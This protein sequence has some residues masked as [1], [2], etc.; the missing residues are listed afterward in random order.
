[1][2]GRGLRPRRLLPARALNLRQR[3]EQRRQPSGAGGHVVG[4]REVVRAE[5]A[6]GDG[7]DAQAVGPGAG[8]VARRVPDDDGA[9]ARPVPGAARG[10]SAAAPRASSASE[11]KP[12]WPGSKKSPMPARA[13][14]SRATGSKLPVTSEER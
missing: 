8:D 7:D 4:L 10:R 2:G 5:R 12:P 9:L 13:S 3:G 1:M 11:P 14:L 6:R